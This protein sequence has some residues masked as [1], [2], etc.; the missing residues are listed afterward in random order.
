MVVGPDADLERFRDYVTVAL[1]RLHAI[2]VQ[3]V[4]WGSGP[5]R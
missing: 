2:G 4:V 5:T 1:R 3:V